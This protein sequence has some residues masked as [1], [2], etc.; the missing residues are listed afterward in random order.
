MEKTS[1]IYVAGHT[2][3]V[4]T[5]IYKQLIER[6][7][8]PFGATHKELDLK[9]KLDVD[10][11]F[12]LKHPEYVFLCA[13]KVGGILANSEMPANFIYDNI[14]IQSNVIEA[15]HKFKV[16]KLCFLGS[17]CI[18]PKDAPTPVK[19][20]SLL[21][22]PLEPTNE[23]Y[24]IAKI[25]G[26]KMCQSFRRQYGCKF[27][28]VMPCNL[29]G[30][31]DNFHPQNSHVIP[32]LIRKFVTA[33]M[34]NKSLVE[35]WGTGNA[36]REFMY[37]DDMADACIYLMDNHLLINDFGPDIINIGT[38]EEIS[39]RQLV[40]LISDLT[41]YNG[42]IVWDTS[43]PD[44]T[45]KRGLDSTLLYQMGW[46]RSITLTSGLVNTIDWYKS[47]EHEKYGGALNFFNK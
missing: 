43:K 39:I 20:S 9:N 35:V 1:R 29:Y 24:A 32:A 31:N 34:E 25:A 47:N 14:V 28:S 37:V 45:A 26:I 11:F 46:S 15:C 13:A 18:Y 36:L 3:L 30:P 41:G 40:D 2:G 16:K 44:G 7:Y 6:G 8:N 27:F 38:G 5:A 17:C 21:T 10:A 22:G 23:P 19:E 12:K 42:E 4:G 33:K